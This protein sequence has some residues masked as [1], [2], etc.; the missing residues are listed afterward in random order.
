MTGY[1]TTINAGYGQGVYVVSASSDNSGQYSAWQ[2]FDKNNSLLW[3]ASYSYTMNVPYAGSVVTI[4]A[5]GTSYKGEWLQIQMP[6]AIVLA[7]Y[8]LRPQD[9][10][11]NTPSAWYVLGSRDGINWNLIDTRAGQSWVSTIYN[12]YQIQSSQAFTH[13]RFVC[14]MIST[15]TLCSVS[16]WILNGTIESV[17][18]TADG[19]VGLGVVAPV[20]ALEVAGNAIVYGYLN[21]SNQPLFYGYRSSTNYS[22]SN[23]TTFVIFVSNIEVVNVGSC[24]NSTTGQFTCPI[25][26]FYEVTF[27]ALTVSTGSYNALVYLNNAPYT[28]GGS[29]SISTVSQVEQNNSMNVIVKVLSAGSKIDIRVSTSG[30]NAWYGPSYNNTT[31]KLIG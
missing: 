16:E 30:A 29:R 7:S 27:N 28:S 11:V 10:P 18:I 12:T 9:G 26:G 31:I 2:A 24:Y 23:E 1:S 13:F 6:C 21:M 3:V 20:E 17:N 15:N 14:Y 8:S 4:D 5:N 19:R 25:A 22:T